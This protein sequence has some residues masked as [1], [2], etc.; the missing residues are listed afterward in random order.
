MN[1]KLTNDDIA[2]PV[3]ARF[4][5][6]RLKKRIEKEQKAIENNVRNNW[7]FGYL[8]YLR[9]ELQKILGEEK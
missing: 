2:E 3:T 5:V 1:E 9:D 6:E 4:I 7:D 8:E